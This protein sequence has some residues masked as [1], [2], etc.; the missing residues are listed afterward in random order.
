MD[1]H[2][3]IAFKRIKNIKRRHST[4]IV[5]DA[6]S[7]L[8]DEAAPLPSFWEA[9]DVKRPFRIQHSLLHNPFHLFVICTASTK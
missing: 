5:Y 2:K 8:K 4:S 6:L 7:F 3:F 1:Y 9:D